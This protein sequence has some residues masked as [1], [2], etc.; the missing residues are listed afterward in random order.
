VA[1]SELAEASKSKQVF[2]VTMKDHREV[3]KN[4]YQVASRAGAPTEELHL[5]CENG[6]TRQTGPQM[7][8][9]H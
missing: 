4:G 5:H 8:L 6:R 9:T 3:R 2:M 7:T 1:E